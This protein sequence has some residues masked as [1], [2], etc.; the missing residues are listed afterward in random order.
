M[1]YWIAERKSAGPLIIFFISFALIAAIAGCAS[2]PASKLTTDQVKAC[3][4]DD[5][6]DQ[7]RIDSEID[8]R[9]DYRSRMGLEKKSLTF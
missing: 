2:D 5:T 9:M 4:V 7:T 1:F 8:D 6:N 3:Q